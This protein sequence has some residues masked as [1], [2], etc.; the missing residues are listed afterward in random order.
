MKAKNEKR[1]IA[2]NHGYVNRWTKQVFGIVV[3]VLP[4]K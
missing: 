2:N 4:L 1:Q 3:E